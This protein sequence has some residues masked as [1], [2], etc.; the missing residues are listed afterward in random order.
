[1]HRNGQEDLLDLLV[2]RPYEKAYSY[3]LKLEAVQVHLRDGRSLSEA[4]VSFGIPAPL[5]KNAGV[6]NIVKPALYRLPSRGVCT[7]N[8]RM[9]PRL[10]EYGNS[11]YRQI[12]SNS[13][14]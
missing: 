11:K 3:G 9:K 12:F 14:V 4:T 1:M 8:H 10:Q 5:S 7:V 6:K 13:N 2:D